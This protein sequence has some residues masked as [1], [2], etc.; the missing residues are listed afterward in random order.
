MVTGGAIT[1]AQAAT[2][3][4][5]GLPYTH[6]VEPLPPNA[7]AEGG[8]ARAA[9]MIEAVYRVEDTAALRVDIG[10]GLRDVPHE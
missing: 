9:R 8:Q 7:V 4:Q 6:I 5:V 1:L 3:V 2:S 10:R